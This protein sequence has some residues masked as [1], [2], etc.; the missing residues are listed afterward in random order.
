MVRCPPLCPG[1]AFRRIVFE[2]STDPAWK[3]ESRFTPLPISQRAIHFEPYRMELLLTIKIKN[4]YQ[5][6]IVR[7]GNATYG[8]RQTFT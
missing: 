6:P 4:H 7:V 8:A 3:P 1:G 2:P 5:L